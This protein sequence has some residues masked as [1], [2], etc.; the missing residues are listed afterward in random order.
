MI[1]SLAAFSL[2]AHPANSSSIA[3]MRAG[4][5]LAPFVLRAHM[6]LPVAAGGHGK[7]AWLADRSQRPTV[8][9]SKPPLLPGNPIVLFITVD[10]L[11]ADVVTDP[12]RATL[13][14]NLTAMRQAG[15]ITK[16][17]SSARTNAATPRSHS[18]HFST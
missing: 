2:G 7:S 5:A 11:R 4:S 1:C 14:P 6:M 9:A 10:A 18:K 15:A 3:M 13:L 12:R 17:R 8:D 16:M